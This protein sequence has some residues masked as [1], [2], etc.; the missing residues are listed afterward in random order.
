M[1]NVIAIHHTQ[2]AKAQGIFTQ[3]QLTA[4]RM[5]F[6]PHHSLLAASSARRNYLNGT[7]SPA[8]VV[9]DKRAELRVHVKQA[10]A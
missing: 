7:Q 10:S 9:S 1:S 3:I 2:A 4:L 8:K 6:S 5:G